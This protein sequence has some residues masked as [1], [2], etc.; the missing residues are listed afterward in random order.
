MPNRIFGGFISHNSNI[1]VDTILVIAWGIWKRRCEI[2]HN[3]PKTK[4]G[5]G[6]LSFNSIKWAIGLIGEFKLA[7][8]KMGKD[9]EILKVRNL[10]KKIDDLFIVF[11][12]ASYDLEKE[13]SAY[14]IVVTDTRGN[15]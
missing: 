7:V 1:P 15:Y 3:A 10:F 14:G 12:D 8:K 11:L 4:R 6:E 9:H 2:I 13:I 5:D